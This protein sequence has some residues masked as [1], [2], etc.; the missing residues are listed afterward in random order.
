MPR[1]HHDLLAWQR[2]IGLV[3]AIY[4]VSSGFPQGEQFGLTSQMRRAAISVPA[5]IAEG[6]GRSSFR[7]R[8]RFMTIARGSL[9]ELETYVVIARELG[10]VAETGELEEAVDSV[11]GLINGLINSE[12]RK[13][14]RT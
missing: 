12:R 2:A 14:E 4:R 8:I 3:K 11:S 1:K 7:D 10:Y 9:N 6:V 5:N 13:A